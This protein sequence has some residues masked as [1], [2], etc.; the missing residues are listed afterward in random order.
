MNAWQWRL[1][2]AVNDGIAPAL[3]TSWTTNFQD[4]QQGIGAL[5]GGNVA[6]RAG[7]D[8][9]N[10]SVSIATVGVPVG[11]AIAGVSAPEVFGGGN[12]IVAAGGSIL[13]GSYD[14]GRGQLSLI[15]GA[16][17]GPTPATLNGGTAGAA[18]VVGLG[19][20]SLAVTARGNRSR[21]SRRKSHSVGNASWR[22]LSVQ[23]SEL[24][25]KRSRN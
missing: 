15:A 3:A 5:A 9:D 24:T 12:L 11:G 8:I 23:R 13:G 1:G 25:P 19:D 4:F 16:D 17:V 6:I 22:F 10:L 20:A 7:G 18:P 21:L 14:V 2:S